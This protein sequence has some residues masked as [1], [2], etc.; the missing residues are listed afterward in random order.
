MQDS[1][2]VETKSIQFMTK[3]LPMMENYVSIDFGVSKDFCVGR[4]EKLAGAGQVNI[5]SVNMRRDSS[6]TIIRDKEK[7]KSECSSHS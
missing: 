2:G 4:E 5:V 1:E 7:E 3:V 6:R